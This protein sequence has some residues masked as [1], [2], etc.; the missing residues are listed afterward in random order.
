M[1]RVLVKLALSAV[2]RA[3][4][5]K[6]ALTLN[7]LG[8]VTSSQQDFAIARRRSP[9]RERRALPELFAPL[10]SD[11]WLGSLIPASGHTLQNRHHRCRLQHQ[12]A[13]LADFFSGVLV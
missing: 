9:A 8:G 7:F 3:S 2:E 5:P 4:R 12:L 11:L 1:S 6:Q 10:R 13:S